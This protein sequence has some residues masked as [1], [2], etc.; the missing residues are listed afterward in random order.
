MTTMLFLLIPMMANVGVSQTTFILGFILAL[1]L[2]RLRSA[3]QP[4]SSSDFP[5]AMCSGST[6]FGLLPSIL[7][8]LF[9][10]F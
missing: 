9:L 8:L 1:C 3:Q 7:A 2:K 6:G 5:T 4:E 10:N